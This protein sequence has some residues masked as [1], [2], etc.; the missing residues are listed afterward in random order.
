MSQT[1]LKKKSNS[2]KYCCVCSG[3]Y[4][5]KVVGDKTISLHK[6]PQDSKLQRIWIQ[7][8]RT[9]MKDFKWTAHKLL[10]SLHF[11]G[12]RGPT[13]AH[14]IPSIFPR[15]DGTE[16]LFPT[17]NMEDES[18]NVCVPET[19]DRE[20]EVGTS[21]AAEHSEDVVQAAKN[22]DEAAERVFLQLAEYSDLDVSVHLHDYA[23]GPI[24]LPK[25]FR[26]IAT[27]TYN[28]VDMRA[29]ETQTCF[30]VMV[31]AGTQASSGE[32]KDFSEQTRLPD[33]VYEDIRH[34][35]S[36]IIFYTGIPDK[37]TFDALFDEMS[38]ASEKTSSNGKSTSDE[39][40]GGRPRSLRLIDEFLM[41]LMRLRLGLLVDDL[42]ARFCIS[43]SACSR[44]L[45]S[46]I[47]YLDS[48][49]DFLIMWPS[50]D[51]VEHNMP[52]LFRDKFPNTRVIIDCTEIRTETPSSTKLKTVLYSDYKSHMTYKS[53]VGISPSGH[54]TF[55]SDLWGGGISD[56]QITKQSGL[57]E[58]CE[59]G[60]AIM[61]DKGFLISDLTT[62]RGVKLI[63]P[64]FKKAH[65]AFSAR[66]VQNTREI[67]NARIH[68][69]RQ[70]ERIKILELFKA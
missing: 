9:V 15:A 52:K 57:I 44:V 53:L 28:E 39:K 1:V 25:K 46:W 37:V 24:Q 18:A 40:A 4:R 17:S 27:Q 20:V 54:V 49:L 30:K 65:K 55:V 56:K 36:K 64:P 68:V 34:D 13:K 2:L 50:K 67:A 41:V 6:F 5:G 42:S 47:N 33:L 8:C 22:D 10:C 69:E 51:A 19:V 14:N 70:M 60:D 16:K 3:V 11:I 32:S 23:S 48:K 63:I 29:V 12:S 62:P 21:T 31:D 66:E 26:N 35:D 61:A 59:S 45:N 43:A 7:R 38:D 58:L